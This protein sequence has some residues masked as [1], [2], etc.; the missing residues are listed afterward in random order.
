MYFYCFAFET[1]VI[2]K[3]KATLESRGAGEM[4]LQLKSASSS[5]AGPETISQF[6]Y[7]AAHKY[8]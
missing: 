1:Y 5:S 7:L 4:I 3:I 6:P 8:L 2:C